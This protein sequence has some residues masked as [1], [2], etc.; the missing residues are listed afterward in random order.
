M[1]KRLN[2]ATKTVMFLAAAVLATAG[3]IWFVAYREIDSHFAAKERSDAA[4][5][6]QTLSHVFSERVTGASLTVTGGEIRRVDSPSLD[7]FADHAVVDATAAYAGGVVTVFAFDKA[8][9]QFV[10]RST[11]V[12]KENGERAIGTTLA[13]DHPAQGA[14]RKGQRYVGPA[15]LF[16]R[17]FFTIY[18][19]TVD[20]AG[21][22]NGVLFVGVPVE[23]YATARRSSLMT[24]AAT[25]GGGAFL[26]CCVAGFLARRQFRPLNDIALR[27][28]QLADGVLDAPI[29][30]QNR[31]DEIGGVARSLETLRETSVRAKML[32]EE[33]VG[34]VERR[35]A[36]RSRRDEAIAGFR[37]QVSRHLATLTGGTSGLRERAEDM[38]RAASEA[39]QAIA[40]ATH[41]S[42][43]TSANVGAVASATEELSVS[44]ADIGA[45]LQRA[46][47]TADTAVSEAEA[48]DAEITGLS[49]AAQ[50]IGDVVDL[51]R[52]I[53]DQTNLLAL[54]ATI[55]AA[56]A[57]ESG[58]GFA[59]VAQEVKT[60]ATQTAKATEEIA[61]QIASVQSSTDGAVGAIRR[62]SERVREIN[63]T[64][65]VIAGAVVQ[66][67]SATR[68]ISTNV[69][70]AARGAQEI[71]HGLGTVEAAAGRTT[72]TAAE[73]K[74]A[75]KALDVLAGEIEREVESFLTRVAS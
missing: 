67:G 47:A 3:A 41:G 52:S 40:M 22:V 33:Q 44:I 59:V 21:A 20:K 50:R 60:L 46:K 68:E 58:K 75:A 25:A 31:G 6:L 45:Q 63:E 5:V 64:T 49:L 19:P 53:A 11:T 55:E 74:D 56:R 43:D 54:N 26:V 12:K 7:V 9:D 28:S 51:I 29:H 15:M 36:R 61:K 1:F 48:T 10:R 69:T 65:V 13:G 71:A 16:G 17:Q 38:S 70:H 35:E 14:L 73:V 62:I 24:L 37:D 32:E 57:G 39:G 18:Q 34:E 23:D 2:L 8:K 42:Q 4:R 27:V 30:H 66:Q 72:E